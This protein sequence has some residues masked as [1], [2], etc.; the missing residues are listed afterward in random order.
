MSSV[1]E[2]VE[3]LELKYQGYIIVTYFLEDNLVIS[4]P[5]HPQ[6]ATYFIE[7]YTNIHKCA[8]IV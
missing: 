1:W 2:G 8:K 6:P 5:V 4:H 7:I 3:K